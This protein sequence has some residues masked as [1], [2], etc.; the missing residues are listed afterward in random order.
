MVIFEY[1]EIQHT[2]SISQKSICRVACR[3]CRYYL[4]YY[5][6]YIKFFETGA[7][8]EAK[9]NSNNYNKISSYFNLVSPNISKGSFIYDGKE[10]KITLDSVIFIGCLTL[11]DNIVVQ[12]QKSLLWD[13]FYPIEI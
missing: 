4:L 2:L 6:N 12:N 7:V 5:W 11:E 1:A 9:I 13:I 3:A 8:I 10:L